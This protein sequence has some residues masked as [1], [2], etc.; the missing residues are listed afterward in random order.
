[1]IAS[2]SADSLHSVVYFFTILQRLCT[3]QLCRQGVTSEEFANITGADVLDLSETNDLKVEELSCEDYCAALATDDTFAEMTVSI[4]DCS[5]DTDLSEI[6][7]DTAT[8]ATSDVIGSMS[9][10]ITYY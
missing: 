5:L 8:E 1:M 10:A 7:E 3:V 2:F 6:E 9:C 4:S